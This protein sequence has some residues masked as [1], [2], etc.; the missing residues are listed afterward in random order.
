MRKVFFWAM[1][2]C[3]VALPAVKVSAAPSKNAEMKLLEQRQKEERK[4]LKLREK[5][6]KQSVKGQTLS[7]A[8]R[9]Q[10]KHQLQR[11]KRALREKQKNEKQELKDR[12][13]LMKESQKR[14][15]Q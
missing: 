4:A 3:L 9:E 11:E 13:R 5:Y 6:A 14:V 10:L 15:G 2:A 12:L 8:M 7:P 1:L